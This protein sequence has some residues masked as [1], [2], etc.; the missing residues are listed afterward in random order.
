MEKQV[1][2][3]VKNNKENFKAFNP[4]LYSLKREGLDT[5]NEDNYE[6]KGAFKLDAF[7]G[8]LRQISPKFNLS[9]RKWGFA[10][11]IVTLKELVADCKMRHSWGNRKGQIIEPNEVDITNPDDPFFDHPDFQIRLENGKAKLDLNDPKQKFLYLCF[12]DDPQITNHK[13]NTNTLVTQHQKFEIIDIHEEKAKVAVGLDDKLE[14]YSLFKNVK[15]NSDR[16]IS[17]SRALGLIKDDSKPE[18]QSALWIEI[19][20]RFV[21]NIGLYPNSTKTYQQVWIETA[22]K[23]T[24]ELNRM[25]LIHFGIYKSVI[26]SVYTTGFWTMKTKSGDVK[27][28]VGVKS[29]LDAVKY[30]S[31]KKNFPDLESLMHQT[32]AFNTVFNDGNSDSTS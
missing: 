2:I 24:E 29:F 21:E 20:K 31:D 10:G 8:T 30:F 32:N 19:E 7:L 12:S 11:E 14:A 22:S 9:K 6:S 26:R 27:E 1:I 25:W 3:Q 18:D 4:N 23:T 17:V 16:L 28:L 13:S 15:N 5:K